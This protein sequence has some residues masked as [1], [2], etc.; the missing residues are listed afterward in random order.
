M[1]FAAAGQLIDCY[2][3]IFLPGA[4]GSDRRCAQRIRRQCLVKLMAAPDEAV[5]V[6]EI[7]LDL[8][9]QA[10]GSAETIVLPLAPFRGIVKDYFLVCES[11][12][13][14]VQKSSLAQIEAIDVG[15][16]SLHDEG[17]SLLKERLADKVTMDHDTA[18]RL[19]TLICV[20]HLR[21]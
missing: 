5:K 16:R 6:G 17:S 1:S 7:S 11:H 20:L 2:A 4:S 21:G 14:A 10:D 18:R 13:R 12:Y 9:S 15:R 19:F 8:R 3:A